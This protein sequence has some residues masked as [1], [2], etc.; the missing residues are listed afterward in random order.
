MFLSFNKNN[1]ASILFLGIF[2]ILLQLS[3]PKLFFI[4]GFEIGFDFL[5][6]FLTILLFSYENYKIILLAFVFGLIQDYIVSVEQ[7]GIISFIKSFS[8]FLLGIIKKYQF[9]W[10]KS[11]KFFVIFLI[12]FFHFS[13]YYFFIFNEPYFFI[14]YISIIHSF[15]YF[16]LIF[17]INRFFFN[18]KLI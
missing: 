14:F 8:I 13:V 11:V 7:I 1:L 5:L 4:N 9:I 18:S 3:I 2:F 10:S 15:L 6:I 12:G 17:I 16:I